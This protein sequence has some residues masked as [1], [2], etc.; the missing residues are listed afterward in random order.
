[1]NG[2]SEFSRKRDLPQ[3]DREDRNGN[4]VHLSR[5]LGAGEGGPRRGIDLAID[6]RRV[7]MFEDLCTSILSAAAHTGDW[8]LWDLAIA[9]LP[10]EP[11][12]RPDP[13]HPKMLRMGAMAA[14]NAGEFGR[15]SDA[16]QLAAIRY[17]LA[18]TLTVMPRSVGRTSTG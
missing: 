17:D 8:V 3:P 5:A 16:W 2:R 14:M 18:W 13:D 6:K 7:F 12:R 9:Q 11:R 10:Y 1:M 15:S 4:H